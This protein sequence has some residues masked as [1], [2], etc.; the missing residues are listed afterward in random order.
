[1]IRA[2]KKFDSAEELR[3]QIQKDRKT[4]MEFFRC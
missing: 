4:A 2:E 3:E 1:M